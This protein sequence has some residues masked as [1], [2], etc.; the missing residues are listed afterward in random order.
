M[1][2]V[3]LYCLPYARLLIMT[4]EEIREFVEQR[5]KE[6]LR[7]AMDGR[8]AEAERIAQFFAEVATHGLVSHRG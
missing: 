4:E 1:N 8:E 7:C 5:L 2:S 3:D 6:M